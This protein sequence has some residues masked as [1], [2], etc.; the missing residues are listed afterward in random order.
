VPGESAI[1]KNWSKLDSPSVVLVFGCDGLKA[2]QSLAGGYGTPTT[3]RSN[4]SLIGHQCHNCEGN[5]EWN[6]EA[7]EF[8]FSKW[9]KSM[10][11]TRRDQ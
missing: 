11:I 8:Q 6:D 5:W 4:G 3:P 1:E 2:D 10:R 7:K 9:I